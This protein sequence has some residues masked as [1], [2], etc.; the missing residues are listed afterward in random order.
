MDQA[1]THY[2]RKNS[3]SDIWIDKNWHTKVVFNLFE[4]IKPW[5]F[6]SNWKKHAHERV[7]EEFSP[8]KIKENSAG[9][10]VIV[11][12]KEHLWMLC[13]CT[14]IHLMNNVS[15]RKLFSIFMVFSYLH[16]VDKGGQYSQ[17]SFENILNFIESFQHELN[18][19]RFLYSIKFIIC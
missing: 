8:T 3:G 10:Y 14:S 1:F 6:H 11:R 15:T 5:T 2:S 4:D 7:I 17:T 13:G 9:K 16:V 12:Q 19:E 18:F